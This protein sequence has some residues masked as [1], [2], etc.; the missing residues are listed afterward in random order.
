MANNNLTPIKVSI[1]QNGFT[2]NEIIVT[3][4]M[5]GILVSVA[6]PTFRA[7]VT[8]ARDK[9]A[10][11]AAAEAKDRLSHE[12]AIIL[13]SDDDKPAIDLN[14]LLSRVK[15]ND[16]DYKLIFTISEETKEVIISA[17]G[18]RERGTTGR[19]SEVWRCPGHEASKS[20][21]IEN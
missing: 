16:G 21:L 8:E 10:L 19:A 2:L 13:M 12:Y 9:D 15:T 14:T 5:L 17:V 20:P 7:F 1:G 18:I 6:F 4:V 11:L 3:L